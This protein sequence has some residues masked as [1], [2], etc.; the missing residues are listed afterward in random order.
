[1]TAD[2]RRF[3]LDAGTSSAYGARELKRTIQRYVMQPIAAS[4]VDGQVGARAIVR[5]GLDESGAGLTLETIGGV[6][7]EAAE[8]PAALVVAEQGKF[9]E[10]LTGVLTSAGYRVMTAST[11]AAA[12]RAAATRPPDAALIDTDISD[13]GDGAQLALELMDSSATRKVVLM[14]ARHDGRHVRQA[15]VPLLRK[16]FLRQDVLATLGCPS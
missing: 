11:P 13:G 5:V 8:P 16:P 9:T 3:L 15:G 1:V 7:T 10:W 4:V 2:A 14:S 12:R 6:E